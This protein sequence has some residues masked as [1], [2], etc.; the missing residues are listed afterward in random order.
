VS[1]TDLLVFLTRDGGTTWR[2]SLS[3]PNSM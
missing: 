3:E 2:N 1:G